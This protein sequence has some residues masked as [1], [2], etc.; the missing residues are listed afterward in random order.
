[1]N[2]RLFFIFL[3]IQFA[4]FK[5]VTAGKVPT[6]RVLE[7][8]AV[9]TDAPFKSCHASTIE[10]LKDGKIIAAWFGGSYEG[11]TDV[12]IWSAVC[13]KGKW[14]SPVKIVTGYN[15]QQQQI[16]CWNPVLF[17]SRDNLLYLFY[18]VGPNPRE[19]WGEVVISA[20]NGLTWGKKMKLPDGFLGPIKNKPIQ[21][22]NGDILCP[23]STESADSKKWCA[24]VE[25]ANP[26]LTEWHKVLIDT[27]SNL[28]V[29]QPS[30]I[31]MP[32]GKLKMLCRSRSNCIVETE[33]ADNGRTWSSLKKMDVPNPNSGID[34][35]NLNSNLFALVY[36][37][38][39]SGADWF[40]GRNLLYV[41]ISSDSETWRDVYVLEKEKDGEFSYPAIIA[42][43]N[44][45]YITYTYNRKFIKYVSLQIINN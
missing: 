30:V 41:A 27:S 9:F 13:E 43:G 29:I 34:A 33:S 38:L 8:T 26:A 44:T 36:N 28:G 40:N 23:S 12:C 39:L 24:H 31:I 2:K 4:F 20:D 25:I 17:K 5:P 14:S 15:N 32:D 19:W 22:S 10:K 1:M 42:D 7:N 18:K 3:A 21:L 45:V 37:P 6:V 35:V 11:A 16:P